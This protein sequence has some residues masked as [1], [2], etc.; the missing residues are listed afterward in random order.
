MVANIRSKK[1]AALP[2]KESPNGLPDISQ[3]I[4]M[5]GLFDVVSH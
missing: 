3:I 1:Q 4:L 5:K 2:P